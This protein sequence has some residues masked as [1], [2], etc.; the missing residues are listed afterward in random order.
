MEKA[1][2]VKNI[3][4]SL[5]QERI[6]S[7]KLKIIGITGS[8]G[9]SST[10]YILFKYLKSINIRV[11]MY[12]SIGIYSLGSIYK[13]GDA[14]E[15]PMRSMNMVKNALSESLNN[16]TQVLILE[17]NEE[18]IDKG[19]TK[20]IPF[21]IRAITT[22]IPKQNDVLYP[23]YV[24]LK[25]TFFREASKDT[26]FVMSLIDKDLI[27]LYEEIKDCNVITYT[28][29][30]L[31]KAREVLFDVDYLI[32]SNEDKFDS[33][34]G[35]TFTLQDN[36]KQDKYVIDSNLLMPYSALNI[37][38]AVAIINALGLFDLDKFKKVVSNMVIPGRDEVINVNK[39][40]KVIFSLN[41]V[42]Q[43]EILK[44]YQ[45]RGEIGKLIVVTGSTGLGFKSWDRRFSMELL[46]LDKEKSIDF[47]F[48]YINKYADYVFITTSDKG[49]ILTPFIELEKKVTKDKET[50]HFY[51]DRKEAIKKAIDIENDDDKINVI[52]ISGR[53][54]RSVMCLENGEISSFNDIDEV[55]NI[56]GDK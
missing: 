28:T 54:N 56:I 41:L 12:S 36:F 5:L 1:Y 48:K 26:T 13:Q 14:V 29:N 31:K 6:N 45:E 20:D 43:L 18:A 52:F 47:A 30:Y 44:R 25:K 9:K 33:I 19:L 49:D 22:I 7:K 40:E 10:A 15:N 42:P 3:N 38:C 16:N 32:D 46:T 34:A 24:N 21:T 39:H 11:S 23:N 55:K 50:A 35:I 17:V 4:D 27:D 8:R 2:E 37:T 51:L 53:G